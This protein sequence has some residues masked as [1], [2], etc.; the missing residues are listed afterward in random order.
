MLT[1]LPAGLGDQRIEYILGVPK[2][3]GQGR[4]VSDINF[5]GGVKLFAVIC[6]L[7]FLKRKVVENLDLVIPAWASLKVF[8]CAVT[9]R[10]CFH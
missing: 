3:W 4:V 1:Q 2:L 10:Y 8:Q 6:S 9:P 5:S 7:S